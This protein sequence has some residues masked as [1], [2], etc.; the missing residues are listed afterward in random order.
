MGL[1]KIN[2]KCLWSIYFGI[3]KRL[4]NDWLTLYF[5]TTFVKKIERSW[6]FKRWSEESN[7]AQPKFAV[8]SLAQRIPHLLNSR[9][10]VF[11]FPT[12]TP[13]GSGA[14]ITQ[15][16]SVTETREV[17]RILRRIQSFFF[18]RAKVLK[19]FPMELTK[20]LLSP[21]LNVNCWEIL[22]SI[23]LFSYTAKVQTHKF[24][25]FKWNIFT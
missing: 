19:R 22:N 13:R 25:L 17:S 23:R 10:L 4:H 12:N 1:V 2:L 20:F 14:T 11:S 8:A 18:P 7:S 21:L 24:Y 6:A 15:M 16:L 3:D 9:F 5:T